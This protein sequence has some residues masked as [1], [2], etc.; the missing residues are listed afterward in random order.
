MFLIFEFLS[1]PLIKPR[2]TSE[3]V[4]TPINLLFLFIT[5]AKL[6]PD[7]QKYSKHLKF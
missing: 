6:M 5:K 4:I 3:E 2:L 7:P 1:R